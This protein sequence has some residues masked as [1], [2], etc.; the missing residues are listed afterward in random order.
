MVLNG[1]SIYYTASSVHSWHRQYFSVLCFSLIGIS[2]IAITQ[3][4]E[5]YCIK[6]AIV[7]YAVISAIFNVHSVSG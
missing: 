6:S 1:I 2:D 5:K 3:T 4:D 7:W